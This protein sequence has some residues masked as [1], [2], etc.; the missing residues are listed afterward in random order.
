MVISWIMNVI[1]PRLHKSVVYA[2]TTFKLW[3]NIKKWYA[4]PNI[5][6]IYRLKTEIASCK[7]NRQDVVDFFSKLMG[8]WNEL[9]NYVQISTYT[10]GAAAKIA[11]FMEEDN[12]HQFLMGL[13]GDSF[14]TIRS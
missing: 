7:Q 12:V 3:E 10:C 8:L 13:D 11:K 1:E 2:D 9:D 4:V 14:L 6:R 5:P